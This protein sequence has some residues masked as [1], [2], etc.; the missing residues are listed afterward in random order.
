MLS[1]DLDLS[2]V[3]SQLT[4]PPWP[5]LAKNPLPFKELKVPA[6]DAGAVPSSMKRYKAIKSPKAGETSS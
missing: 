2:Y 4:V 5:Y 3:I 6:A 1:S